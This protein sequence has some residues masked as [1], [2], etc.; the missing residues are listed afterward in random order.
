MPTPLG[1]LTKEEW[2][3]RQ[4]AQ[5][6]EIREHG[7]EYRAM[8]MK[9]I[10]LFDD[11]FTSL[12][13]ESSSVGRRPSTHVDKGWN[14]MG[15]EVSYLWK[16]HRSGVI[17]LTLDLPVDRMLSRARIHFVHEDRN[18]AEEMEILFH[19][20]MDRK[21]QLAPKGIVEVEGRRT[22]GCTRILFK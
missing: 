19:K 6:D 5:C 20:M 1:F 16:N 2:D 15:P 18:R 11:M 4:R 17:R 14:L 7:D 3:E 9:I 22:P 10:P 13:I 12:L 8:L 21:L